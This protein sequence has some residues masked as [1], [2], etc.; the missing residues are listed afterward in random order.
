MDEI[1]LH[2]APVLLGAGRRLFD[3]VERRVAL[4][5]VGALQSEWATHL[6]YRVVR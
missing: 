4:E 2:V 5:P 1:D 3:G 6:R